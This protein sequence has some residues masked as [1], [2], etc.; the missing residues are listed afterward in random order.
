MNFPENL[1]YSKEHTWLLVE[2]GTGTIGITEFAQSELGEIVYV[3]LPNIGQSFK[4]DEIFGSVEA[5]KTTSD[6]FMPVSGKVIEI[7]AA[8]SKEPE[9]VNSDSFGSG[10]M[11]KIGITDSGELDK[12]LNPQ[13]YAAVTGE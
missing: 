8:L 1:L 12:M 13:D 6:L 11:I 7:N 9:L 3:E 4:A 2:D 10:W 5:V